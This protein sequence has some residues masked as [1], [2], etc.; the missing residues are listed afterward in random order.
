MMIPIYPTEI[1]VEIINTHVSA[2]FDISEGTFVRG[3]GYKFVNVRI[4]WDDS[5]FLENFG[6]KVGIVSDG[7]VQH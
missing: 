6:E 3:S 7:I 5:S 2:D 4:V 1:A